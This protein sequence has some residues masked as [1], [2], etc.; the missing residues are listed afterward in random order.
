MRINSLT[1]F[2]VLLNQLDVDACPCRTWFIFRPVLFTPF[3]LL[4][5]MKWIL[6]WDK[7]FYIGSLL[8]AYR[9]VGQNKKGRKSKASFS[10]PTFVNIGDYFVPHFPWKLSAFS[11]WYIRC[12][13]SMSA[14]P[15]AR[16]RSPKHVSRPELS[17]WT[18]ELCHSD[19]CA[20]Q[21]LFGFAFVVN[22][23]PDGIYYHLRMTSY[24]M[25]SK[26]T[27]KASSH[28]TGAKA[29]HDHV[30][31]Q[32]AFKLRIKAKEEWKIISWL[33]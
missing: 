21:Q 29:C 12:T 22:E 4:I 30:I 23:C 33:L 8:F 28:R 2:R 10:V 1:M 3:I 20:R 7:W 24:M 6:G 14:L 26:S 31:F 9:L 17:H 19:V 5:N 15:Q 16:Q 18:R 11:L 13:Q 25:C 27:V 32:S